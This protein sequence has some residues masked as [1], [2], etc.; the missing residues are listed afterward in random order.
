MF[1]FASKIGLKRN[2]WQCVFATQMHK[3]VRHQ[4][5]SWLHKRN[6]A[7]CATGVTVGLQEDLSFASIIWG[8]QDISWFSW[9]Q[10]QVVPWYW[11]L[12]RGL[13]L[14]SEKIN[15]RFALLE[16]NREPPWIKNCVPGFM[17][18]LAD[19]EITTELV[20]GLCLL[21]PEKVPH[22]HL[23]S[24]A[25]VWSYFSNIS[26]LLNISSIQNSKVFFSETKC[27]QS[28]FC[29]CICVDYVRPST[30][31]IIINNHSPL[32]QQR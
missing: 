6:K 20:E 8:E 30:C 10:H 31:F 13:E 1:V 17:R 24:F 15:K 16:G 5:K 27:L 12:P 14:C 4:S 9:F 29:H 32:Y 23:N 3:N 21:H 26:S 7:H 28:I 25:S 11:F 19:F 18:K 2:L 22:L